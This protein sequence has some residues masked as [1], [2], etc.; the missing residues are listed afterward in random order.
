MAEDAITVLTHDHREVEAMFAQA[1]AAMTDPARL[2]ELA[3]EIT[4]ELVRHAVA[5]EQYLYPFAKDHLPGGDAMVSEELDDH[6]EIERTLKD[7]ERMSGDNIEFGPTL[8]TL[9]TD[10]R[11]HVEEEEGQLF[12]LLARQT[13]PG[14]LEELGEKLTRAK[15][16]APT[17]PH[18][19]SPDTPPMNKILAPGVGLVD[20]VRDALSGRSSKA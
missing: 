17:R 6:R 18:P 9:M 19:S 14:Q 16:M 11:S 20:R 3:D 12:P 2:K 15:K 7:L 4:I 5:E 1:E 10:V 13:N 8:R